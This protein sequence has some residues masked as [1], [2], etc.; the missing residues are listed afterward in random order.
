[1]Q[2]LQSLILDLAE[3]I[4]DKHLT[5]LGPIGRGGFATVYKGTRAGARHCA[6]SGR[7][8]LAL[9]GFTADTWPAGLLRARTGGP[10]CLPAPP[11]APCLPPS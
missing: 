2:E 4:K 8:R 5:V 10:A 9:C 1:M 3:A 11:R 7:G 6:V